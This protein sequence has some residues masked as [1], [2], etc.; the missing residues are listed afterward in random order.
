MKAA[1]WLNLLLIKQSPSLTK[2]QKSATS[3]GLTPLQSLKM[4]SKDSTG[5]PGSR[6]SPS[7]FQNLLTWQGQLRA[8][9]ITTPARTFMELFSSFSSGRWMKRSLGISNTFSFSLVETMSSRSQWWRRHLIIFAGLNRCFDQPKP[10]R[11]G[12]S[13]SP[14][15]YS[16][17]I[18]S[19][20]CSTRRT[21]RGTSRVDGA[22][23]T[24]N[25][26][27]LPSTSCIF[28]AFRWLMACSQR[29]VRNRSSFAP[30][31]NSATLWQSARSREAL[32]QCK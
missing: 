10:F 1:T 20:C 7:I 32:Q 19:V 17:L 15:A 28:L 2:G 13:P 12:T 18:V 14:M 25:K 31:A 6:R 21:K 26:S 11:R 27:P 4:C 22:S 9:K 3:P 23:A 29:S 30:N 8:N 24:K 5:V 16:E